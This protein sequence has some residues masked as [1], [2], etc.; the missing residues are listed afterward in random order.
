MQKTKRPLSPHLSIY[1]KQITSVLS[2]LHRI[3]GVVLYG[4]MLLIVITLGVIV[5][6]PENYG[7]LHGLI[8][9][10]FGK[11]FIISWAFAFYYHF[12]NG[13]RHL[14]WDMGY[15]FEVSSVNRSGW[16]VL[17]FTIAATAISWAV[18]CNNTALL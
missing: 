13:I 9:T 7:G 17:L 14:F 8:V 16:L 18:A 10:P 4:G 6:C 2:I 11:A 1:K 3:T 5:Y 15:G 12:F